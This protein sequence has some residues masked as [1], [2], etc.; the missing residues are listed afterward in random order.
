MAGVK[1]G[2]DYQAFTGL[3]EAKKLPPVLYFF[4]EDD[5]LKEQAVASC[6]DQLVPKNTRD[7]NYLL[8]YAEDTSPEEILNNSLMPPMMAEKRVVVVRN[9]QRFTDARAKPL[10][11]YAEKKP[12]D[13]TCLIIDDGREK[14]PARN[15]LYGAAKKKGWAVNCKPLYD[16]QVL[17]WAAKY[18]RSQKINIDPDALVHLVRLTG[19]NL[20]ALATELEKVVVFAG[21]RTAIRKKQVEEVVA[22]ARSF[23]VYDLRNKVGARDLPGALE[24]LGHMLEQ[25]EA[26]VYIVHTL[27]EFCISLWRCREMA[28]NGAD[29]YAMAGA[30]HTSPFFVKDYL[31]QTR[32]YTPAELRKACDIL[33][34]ADAKLKRSYAKPAVILDV[35]LVNIIGT[36]AKK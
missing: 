20:R 14:P 31:A 29:Q 32:N 12:P 1:D 7:F 10:A 6:V 35:A 18:A 27:G 34:D 24:I 13:T 11:A 2:I 19:N 5:F 9:F 17:A 15:D 23:S 22:Q 8:L 30:L 28:A 25:G 33:L 26:P 3:L 21:A 4:G 36:K 16:N